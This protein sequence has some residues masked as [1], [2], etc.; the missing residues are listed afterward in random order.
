MGNGLTHYCRYSV[1]NYFGARLCPSVTRDVDKLPHQSYYGSKSARGDKE[2]IDNKSSLDMIGIYENKMLSQRAELAL[3]RTKR[4]HS[5][6]DKDKYVF[7][8]LK[9]LLIYASEGDTAISSSQFNVKDDRSLEM[10]REAFTALA[11]SLSAFDTKS[12][13][14]KLQALEASSKTLADG[15]LINNEKID[16]LLQ[17]VRRYGIVQEGIFRKINSHSQDTSGEWL[18]V[19]QLGYFFIP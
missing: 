3:L 5:I 8:M 19:K 1:N 10:L 17:F 13:K 9:D 4:T 6:T 14:D 16:D 18:P 2:M 12:F 11:S 7:N 15:T